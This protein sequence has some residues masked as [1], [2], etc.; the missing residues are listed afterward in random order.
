VRDFFSTVGEFDHLTV[1]AGESLDLGDFAIRIE[2]H[3]QFGK[4][5]SLTLNR[6]TRTRFLFA[7]L[8]H[9]ILSSTRA[10]LTPTTGTAIRRFIWLQLRRSAICASLAGV[11]VVWI[12]P[13][14]LTKL[15]VV[16]R[17]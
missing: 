8:L 12:G 2:A 1:T 5:V 13:L 6:L 14:L 16:P 9:T 10:C 15:L 4:V 7:D 11:R 17:Q 3:E